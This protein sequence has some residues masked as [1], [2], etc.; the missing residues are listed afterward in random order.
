EQELLERRREP[1]RWPAR[2]LHKARHIP[3]QQV[4]LLREG[5]EIGARLGHLR[6][7][8]LLNLPEAIGGAVAAQLRLEIAPRLLEG[9]TLAGLDL[10]ESDDVIAELR[11]HRPLDLAH[12]HA[13]ERL[14]ERRD[15][16]AALRPPQ[17]A[18]VLGR[19]RVLGVLLRQLA[20]VLARLRLG[21][22]LLRLR[23]GCGVVLAGDE[24]VPRVALL[25][26]FQPAPA[27]LV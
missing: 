7:Q 12:T 22:D 17:I 6:L 19:A 14:R 11:L 24:N 13:V 25:R 2:A 4:V 18:A 26:H 21:E 16:A 23:E 1:K 10:I 9:L 3:R 5:A 8:L 27:L 20:K 15:E